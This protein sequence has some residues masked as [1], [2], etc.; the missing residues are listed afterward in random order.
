MNPAG[1]GKEEEQADARDMQAHR[2]RAHSRPQSWSQKPQ[3]RRATRAVSCFTATTSGGE[4]GP[5]RVPGSPKGWSASVCP[6]QPALFPR[7]DA[8][9]FPCSANPEPKHSAV[10]SCC[11]LQGEE[12][13]PFA[14]HSLLSNPE[15]P[16]SFPSSYR[17][18]NRGSEEQSALAQASRL[19]SGRARFP[20]PFSPTTTPPLCPSASAGGGLGLQGTMG[21]I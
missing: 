16:V 9:A 2:P 14:E 3:G 6:L 12:K 11:P 1:Q 21:N 13:A 20:T 19:V 7:T 5:R 4:G 10:S 15:R 8:P 17:R 18:G